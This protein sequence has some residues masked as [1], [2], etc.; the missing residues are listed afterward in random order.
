MNKQLPGRNDPCV[1]GSGK[2]YKKCCLNLSG[3]DSVVEIDSACHLKKAHHYMGCGDLVRAESSF[4]EV[5]KDDKNSVDA[6]VGLGQCLC[7]QWRN[8]EGVTLL[9]RAGKILVRRARKARD[10]RH[11][12]D[13]AYLMIELQSSDKA[14][15]LLN[16]AL[17]ITPNFPR[18]HHTKALAL[19]KKNIKE[20]CLSAKRA[21]ELAP[22]ESNA[23]ILLAS[24]EAK[25]GDLLV[26]KQRL[27][28]LIDKG[29]SV[30][31][32]RANLELGVV[33]DRLGDYDQA[34]SCFTE[35][36]KLNQK[37]PEVMA[38]DKEAVYQE[39]ERSKRVFDAEYLKNCREKVDDQQA[40]PVFLIGFYRSGTTLM[41]QI[42]AAHPQ[43]VS[44]DE[45]YILPRVI[46][47]IS[48][49]S[50][51]EG[52]IQEKI[53]ALT[54]EQVTDMRLFYWHTAEKMMGT[55]LS[56]KVFIDKTAMNTLNLGLINTLFPEAIILF[57]LRDPRDVVLSCFM[58]SFGLSPLT[59]HFLDWIDGARFYTFVMDYWLYV[60]DHLTMS[61][62]ELRYEDVLNDMEGQFSPVFERMGLEWSLECTQFY[63]YAR[64]RTVSTPSF[65][66][67]TKPIYHS[68]V[69]RWQNYK[70]Q[71][72]TLGSHFN[73][74]V[75][76]LKY[77]SEG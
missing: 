66:Q 16:E 38:I 8:N 6:L 53:K 20:A 41:E 52:K 10:I 58:Q 47:E 22:D 42:L 65:D 33:L 36:G 3:K 67:V 30:D 34:F 73:S 54:V 14:L 4:R 70:D 64:A 37:K 51:T 77:N 1:C 75:R 25:Q 43:V 40:A 23:V 57:A 9:L 72:P 69:R 11:L 55:T 61:W 7:L 74:F 29:V 18:A 49:I 50:K 32:A 76:D 39:I 68:S 21:V 31:L 19:Q 56:G 13:L 5:L 63:K 26:A 45:A 17:A 12:L 59:V 27:Q 71:F 60:R 15:P 44:S 46:Q 35:A 2:K 62:M 28:V 48:R 24:L